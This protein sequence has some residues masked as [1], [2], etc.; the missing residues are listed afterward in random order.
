[1]QVFGNDSLETNCL[2]ISGCGPQGMMWQHSF[3]LPGDYPI[4]IWTDYLGIVD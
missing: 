2:L 3:A 4:A 1:M